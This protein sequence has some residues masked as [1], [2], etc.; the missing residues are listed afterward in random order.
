MDAVALAQ[1]L[2]A[3]ALSVRAVIEAF[4]DRID[5]VNPAINAI[6]SLRPQAE[7]LAEAEALDRAGPRGPLW[8]LP[9][10]VKDLV[11]TKGLRT[12]FGSPIFADHVPV[13]DHLVSARLRAA[14]AILIGKTNTP[15][16]GHGS[17]SFN[18]VF[19]ATRNPYDPGRSA[20][21]SSGGAAA[22]LA[23]RLVPLA[24]GSDMTRSLL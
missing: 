3:G 15:E 1:A 2:R 14:G 20:G 24:D 8:G 16:W 6:V 7:L 23:A 18:P 19:G 12:T 10:A 5:A 9:V 21:G 11:A 17:H 22:A 13:A 4:L